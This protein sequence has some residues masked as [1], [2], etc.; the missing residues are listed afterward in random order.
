[1]ALERIFLVYAAR[2]PRAIRW[3]ALLVWLFLTAALGVYLGTLW[4]STKPFA[5]VFLLLALL[6]LF[7]LIAFLYL[8]LW[9]LTADEKGLH[10]R[11][12][13]RWK[14]WSW[15]QIIRVTQTN[16]KNGLEELWVCLPKGAPVYLS[17]RLDGYE[18]VCK[19]LQQHKTFLTRE[20]F[21]L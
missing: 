1:M 13:F 15:N 2:K 18:D 16:D 5:P 11:R 8:W 19:I 21:L 6:F 20:H 17:S 14:H 12:L 9:K 4:D 3:S 7:S 10:R